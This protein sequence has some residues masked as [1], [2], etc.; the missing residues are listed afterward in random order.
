MNEQIMGRIKR[1]RRR[2]WP[3]MIVGALIGGA[4]GY[5]GMMFVERMHGWKVSTEKIVAGLVWMIL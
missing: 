5:F 3:Q 1:K 2:P 4:C